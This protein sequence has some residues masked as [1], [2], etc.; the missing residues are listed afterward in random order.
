VI[1]DIKWAIK[2]WLYRRMAWKNDLGLF[3]NMH[4]RIAWAIDKA[5]EPTWP[6]REWL[7]D[8]GQA[9]QRK[10]KRQAVHDVYGY[11]DTAQL[12]MSDYDGNA[13]EIYTYA[14]QRGWTGTPRPVKD[15]I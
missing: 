4:P 10:A 5:Y 1:E 9:A 7:Y 13:A 12:D 11:P 15:W 14:R 3:M 2:R 8:I 6:I